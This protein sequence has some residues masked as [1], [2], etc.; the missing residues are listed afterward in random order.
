MILMQAYY[1]PEFWPTLERL[2]VIVDQHSFLKD[3]LDRQRVVKQRVIEELAR[4]K[5]Q[6]GFA[7]LRQWR[8]CGLQHPGERLAAQHGSQ[9]SWQI[10][11]DF[12]L[13]A[14]EARRPLMLLGD[15]AASAIRRDL[16]AATETNTPEPIVFASRRVFPVLAVLGTFSDSAQRTAV[17]ALRPLLAAWG[18]RFINET[19]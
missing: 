12:D 18:V 13:D 8:E 19:M 4:H 6:W 2:E 14:D 3:H 15:F 7:E 1:P 5:S 9:G 17:E 10:T 11:L 16:E